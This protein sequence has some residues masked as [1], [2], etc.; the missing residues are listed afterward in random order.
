M[1]RE[2]KERRGGGGGRRGGG[3]GGG[4][5]CGRERGLEVRSSC[6]PCLLLVL[7]YGLSSDA[8]AS[9]RPASTMLPVARDDGWRGSALLLACLRA[10]RVRG[11]GSQDLT[12]DAPSRV[13]GQGQRSSPSTSAG[14]ASKVKISKARG[15]SQGRKKTIK[16]TRL[17]GDL[18]VL[19]TPVTA[20]ST[21][22]SCSPWEREGSV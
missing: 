10:A 8:S 5:G 12:S 13:R 20:A 6:S 2:W 9:S 4:G 17:Q 3:G 16:N 11:G 15:E 7:L 21:L 19:L 14:Q 22:S 1:L 18:V